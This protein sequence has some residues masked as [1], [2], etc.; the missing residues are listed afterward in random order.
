MESGGNRVNE[1]RVDPA[2]IQRSSRLELK[3]DD[4]AYGGKGIG[5]VSDFVIF[6]SNA[7]PGDMVRARVVKR[8]KNHA[9]AVI[10]EILTPSPKR[11]PATCPHSGE[12]GGCTWQ[13][14]PYAEQLLY[15][16]RLAES[17]IAHLGKARPE[18]VEE[19]I[20]SP[21]EWR[22]RNKMDFTFG[23]N[24]DGEP[25]IGFHSQGAFDSILEVNK[26]FLQPEIFDD[27]LATMTEW[28]RA[29]KLVSYDPRTHRG[30]LRHLILRHSVTTGEMI[31]VLLTNEQKLPNP[32][33]LIAALRK[34]CPALKGFVWGLNAG[35]ADFVKMDRE[36]WR[37]GDPTLEEVLDGLRFRISALSFF[38]VNTLAAEKLYSVARDMLG[39]DARKS[40]LLDAYCGTGSIGIF[41]AARVREVVGVEISREAIWDARENAERN[42]MT[43]CTFMAGDMRRTLPLVM[44]MPGGRIERIVVDPPRGGMDKHSLRSL[45]EIHAPV[46]VYVS[47]NPA[48]LSR[49]LVTITEAGYRATVMQPV[50][51]F[52]QTYHIETVVRFEAT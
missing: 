8:A 49:D 43:N 28:M 30:N 41:C 12:C 22:Y 48:T 50:D 42:G 7:V 47:C 38:Q 35:L 11:I 21:K 2:K 40:R 4:L 36:I 14:L 33:D 37:W 6:V 23:T 10:E 52:P 1:K 29:R 46:I 26:C 5:R 45:L 17:T 9:E 51:L 3:I 27:F 25:I 19:I 24:T 13:N 15:K 16:Q 32:E 34:A 20:P 39:E 18:R 31:A 44:S